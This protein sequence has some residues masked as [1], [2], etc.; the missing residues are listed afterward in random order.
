VYALRETVFLFG[1]GIPLFFSTGKLDVA[2]FLDWGE[3]SFFA[4]P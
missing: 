4:S 1:W 3:D 2:G